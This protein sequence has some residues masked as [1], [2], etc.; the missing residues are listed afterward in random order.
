MTNKEY[1]RRVGRWQGGRFACSIWCA[2]VLSTAVA[3]VGAAHYG[4]RFASTIY[5]TRLNYRVRRTYLPLLTI[6]AER[7]RGIPYRMSPKSTVF[8]PSAMST[9]KSSRE[10]ATRLH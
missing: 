5:V 7:L 8:P 10:H 4:V 6:Q 9:C 3:A 1:D 2:P